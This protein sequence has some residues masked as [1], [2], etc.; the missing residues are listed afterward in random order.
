MNNILKYQDLDLQIMKI[1]AEINQ[2]SD[3]KNAIKMQTSLKEYQSKLIE[4]NEKTKTLFAEFENYKNVFNQM[5]ENLEVV[6]KN[7][8][9]KDEKKID[10]LIE[11]SDA[12]TN[13]L[14]RLEK[15]ISAIASECVA[16]QNEYNN[17][18]KNARTAKTA[19]QKHKESF[20]NAKLEGEAK[21]AQLQQ[22]K[23][24][25]SKSVDSKL[26]AIY[27]QKHS[28]KQNVFVVDLGGKCGGCRVAIPVSKQAKLKAEGMIECENCGR[29]IFAK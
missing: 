11:A 3:R 29:I 13:N 7:I 21:I 19:L 8:D 24:K 28:D 14:M 23:E 22:E 6:G 5:A 18:M 26:L 9:A 10:G 20:A 2:N 12:I 4:L 25:L 1:E 17:I 15:K 16:V 27:N